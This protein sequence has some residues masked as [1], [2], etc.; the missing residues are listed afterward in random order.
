MGEILVRKASEKDAAALLEIYA[1]YVRNTAVSFEYEVPSPGEFAARIRNTE[2]THPYLAAEENGEIIGYAYAGPFIR[3]A[4]YDRCAETTVYVR[5]DRRRRGAGAAL[6]EALEET[7]T[8]RGILNLYACIAVTEDPADPYLSNDSLLFHLRQ[9]FSLC[10]RFRSCGYKFG[11]WYDMVWMEKLTGK[12]PV[13][14][15]P[16]AR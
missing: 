3:R 10:G 4:A 14:G 16:D 11:R 13:S 9:G 1:P 6:Y 2:R 5:E 15:T 8:A 7:L 12:H